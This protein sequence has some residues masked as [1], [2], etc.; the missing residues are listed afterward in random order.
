MGTWKKDIMKAV[1]FSYDDGVI[2][3]FSLIGMLDKYGLKGTFNLNSGLSGGHNYFYHSSGKNIC[4]YAVAP[5]DVAEIYKGHEVASHTLTHPFLPDLDEAEIIR[6]V[7]NDRHRLSELVGYEVVGFAYPGGGVNFD[8]RVA[9]IIRNNTGIKYC[10]T[11]RLTDSFDLQDDLYTFV[12]NLYSVDHERLMEVGRRFVERKA[13][14]PQIL[15]IW[16]HSYE[17]DYEPNARARF[18]EFLKLI[19]GHDDIFYGTNKEVLL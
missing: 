18:E 17:L 19:S 7:E 9:D 8:S 10:R 11:T 13:D 5:E 12:P 1:T 6:Q 4:R 16:G 3:D 14:R 15:Y 2:Q